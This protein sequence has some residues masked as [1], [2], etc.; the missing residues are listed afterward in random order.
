M[1]LVPVVLMFQG[2]LIMR[3]TR[4]PYTGLASQRTFVIG[5]QSRLG[6]LLSPLPR[7]QSDRYQPPCPSGESF[8]FFPGEGETVGL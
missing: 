2:S 5:S 1:Y 3:S 4:L 6:Y 7:C 8:G